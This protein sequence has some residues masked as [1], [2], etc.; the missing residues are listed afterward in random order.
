MRSAV[1]KPWGVN[2]GICSLAQCLGR[3][4]YCPRSAMWQ[5]ILFQTSSLQG[6]G[7]S[8]EDGTAGPASPGSSQHL[9]KV[10]ASKHASRPHQTLG[11]EEVCHGRA[12]LRQ[13]MRFSSQEPQGAMCSLHVASRTH[14]SQPLGERDSFCRCGLLPQAAP[15]SSA[16]RNPSKDQAS[17]DWNETTET[18]DPCWD[19]TWRMARCSL[20]SSPLPGL[21]PTPFSLL[22]ND[23]KTPQW[24]WNQLL[25]N[26]RF[27]FRNEMMFATVLLE[28]CTLVSLLHELK[29]LFPL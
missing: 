6:S 29:G 24:F 16:P 15:H 12:W 17:P 22:S 4:P 10:T 11:E 23:R 19:R 26:R 7:D 9:K 5:W 8:R 14:G 27:F 21:L 13:N 20:A 3:R 2:S 18:G 25:R 28:T 1:P